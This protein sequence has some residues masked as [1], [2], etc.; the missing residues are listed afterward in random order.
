MAS[1]KFINKGSVYDPLMPWL[2]EGLLNA[3][4]INT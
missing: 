2:G 1:Q 3:S 4:G